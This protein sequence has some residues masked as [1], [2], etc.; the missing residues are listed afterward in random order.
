MFSL[1]KQILEDSPLIKWSII[2]AGIGGLIETFHILWLFGVWFY[3]K[4]R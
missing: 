4:M 2:A 1:T 3:W